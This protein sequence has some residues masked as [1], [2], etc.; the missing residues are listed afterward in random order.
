[1][2][3]KRKANTGLSYELLVRAIFQAINDQEEVA[4]LTWCNTGQKT[5]F[6]EIAMQNHIR[7]R[8]ASPQP[9]F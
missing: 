9:D 5:G 1:M 4:R 6:D 8:Q 2:M 7:R 3:A